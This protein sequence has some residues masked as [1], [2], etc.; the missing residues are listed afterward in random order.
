MIYG[1]RVRLRAPERSDLSQ[2]VEWFNDPEVREG[3]LMIL[4][5]SLAR[6]EK[7][8][9]DMIKKPEEEQV[10]VIEIELEEKWIIIGTCGFFGFD[11]RC[12]S[13]EV[14]IVIGEKTYWNQGY[15][16]ETMR[17]ML[18]HGFDS[19]NLNRIALDVYDSNRRAIRAYEKAGFIRE[20]I[21]RQGMFKDGRYI[22]IIMMSVLR[23]EWK[24]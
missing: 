8:F 4:P 18:K 12:R 21:K 5:L 23:S 13:A 6:E 15:G 14:G 1:E 16:T 17:M 11:W 24:E 22:D 20:G 7:W 3:I 19:L 9:D 2:F 10:L